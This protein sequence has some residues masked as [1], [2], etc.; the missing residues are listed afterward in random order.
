M[1]NKPMPRPAFLSRRSLISI[2]SENVDPGSDLNQSRNAVVWLWKSLVDMM[3]S[4]TPLRITQDHK[5]TSRVAVK[6]K[7]KKRIGDDIWCRVETL[8][9]CPRDAKHFHTV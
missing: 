8:R 2:C 7:K 9:W 6:K 3:K 4:M 1:A 5:F